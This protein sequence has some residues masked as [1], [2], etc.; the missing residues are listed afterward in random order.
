MHYSS[1]AFHYILLEYLIMYRIQPPEDEDDP[2]PEGWYTRKAGELLPIHRQ[3][4][5]ELRTDKARVRLE[6]YFRALPVDPANCAEEDDSHHDSQHSSI[7]INV[8]EDLKL[9]EAKFP[10]GSR[11]FST[12][13]AASASRF[14]ST[15]RHNSVKI[16]NSISGRR[17]LS[18]PHVLP[19]DIFQLCTCSRICLRLRVLG[20]G[21]PTDVQCGA[22]N[23]A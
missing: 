15:M 1:A 5:S 2:A 23:A 10:R 22:E 4:I 11:H 6:K 16:P 7:D 14:P 17:L 13:S 20:E 3:I 9:G 8:R 21:G 18:S 12:H 19:N